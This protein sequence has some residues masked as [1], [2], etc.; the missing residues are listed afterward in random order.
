MVNK[1]WESQLHSALCELQIR[2]TLLVNLGLG[3]RE[4]HC[5]AD[6][7]LGSARSTRRKLE[8]TSLVSPN[9]TSEK[10]QLAPF[11]RFFPPW[12]NLI[13]LLWSVLGI[14]V[15]VSSLC[16]EAPSPSSWDVHTTQAMRPVLWS[17]SCLCDLLALCFPSLGGGRAV[18]NC[19][20]CLASDFSRLPTCLPNYPNQILC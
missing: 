13:A 12:D 15:R 3:F 16:L 4:L 11:P 14:Q 18:G 5:S 9:V 6:S 19:Y 2:A 1:P 7:Q 20:L 10:A 17:M 8:E